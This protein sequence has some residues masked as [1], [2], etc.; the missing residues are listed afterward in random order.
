MFHSIHARVAAP[1]S[2]AWILAK[3]LTQIALFWNV[4]LLVIPSQI[5]QLEVLLGLDGW[6]PTNFA[7]QLAGSLI[8]GLF[9]ILGGVSALA[10]AVEGHGTP[11]PQ[12]CARDLVVVGPYRYVRN[13]MAIA[14]LTQAVGV[15]LLCG[16]AWVVAYAL[17]GMLVWQLAVRPWEEAD[18]VNR[19]GDSYRDYQKAVRCWIPTFPGYVAKRG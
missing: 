3:T 2:N 4:F 8:F 12:D 5:L 16:S 17:T 11:M 7:M 19:F 18:L 9:G 15:G 10:M 14:G 13:P 6:L 1:A